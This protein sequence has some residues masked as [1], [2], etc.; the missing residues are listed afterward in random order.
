MA[1]IKVTNQNRVV[2]FELND[3]GAA[4]S[5]LDQLPLTINVKNYS[6]DEKVFYP[7]ELSLDNTPMSQG[8]SGDLGYYAPWG[9]VCMFF[10][11]FSSAPGLY[12][13]GHCVAGQDQISQLSGTIKIEEV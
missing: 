9:D 7:K 8:R 4:Q 12:Q 10:R 3:S 6:S 11:D 5:L 13:L 1:K 2:T